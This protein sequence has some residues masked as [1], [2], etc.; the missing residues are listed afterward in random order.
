MKAF[1]AHMENSGSENPL[2]EIYN[3]SIHCT[4]LNRMRFC[5][6]QGLNLAICD[7]PSKSKTVSTT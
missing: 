1:K 4:F 6:I 7:E 5:S 2:K 3:S